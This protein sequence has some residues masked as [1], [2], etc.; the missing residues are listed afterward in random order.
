MVV[1]P[2]AEGSHLGDRV[3]GAYLGRLADRHHPRLD[4][5][6]VADPLRR[7]GHQLRRQFSI[8]SRDGDQLAAEEPLG[9]TALVDVDVGAFGADHRFERSHE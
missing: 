2:G 7:R 4:V 8:G 5:V 9:S 3:T 1:G 6:L